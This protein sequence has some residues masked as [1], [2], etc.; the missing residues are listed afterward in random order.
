MNVPSNIFAAFAISIILSVVIYF[1]K[2]RRNNQEYNRA[3]LV[4]LCLF[5]A[6]IGGTNY[7]LFSNKK[8]SSMALQEVLTGMPD[9]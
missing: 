9:F 8:A 3:D 1:I 4:K 5:G 6:I 7:I 2:I